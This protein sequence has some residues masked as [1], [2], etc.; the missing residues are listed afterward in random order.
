MKTRKDLIT[1]EE[2]TLLESCRS[3]D[4]WGK[5]CDAIKGARDGEYPEDWWPEVKLSGM[6]DRIMGR[7]G[8]DSDLTLLDFDNKTDMINYFKKKGI[9]LTHP[10]TRRPAGGWGERN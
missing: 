6:M 2:L 8:N 1:G 5:A 4:D 9:G 7:W 3:E 10:P